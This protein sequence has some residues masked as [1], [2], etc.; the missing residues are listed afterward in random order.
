MS[1]KATGTVRRGDYKLREQSSKRLKNM[2]VN[3]NGN[4]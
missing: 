4:V 2:E 3:K 1:L